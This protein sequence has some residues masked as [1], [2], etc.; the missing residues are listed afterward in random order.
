MSLSQQLTSQIEGVLEEYKKAVEL[1]KSRLAN[2][3]AEEIKSIALEIEENDKKYLSQIHQFVD[4]AYNEMSDTEEEHDH[5]AI[6]KLKKSI[7]TSK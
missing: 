5:E 1:L 7:M 4:E 6:E 2:A 3:S